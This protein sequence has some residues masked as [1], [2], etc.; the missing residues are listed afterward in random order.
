M[1]I[2]LIEFAVSSFV[3]EQLSSEKAKAL[4]L[5]EEESTQVLGHGA[6]RDDTGTPGADTAMSV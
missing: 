6:R 1:S 2:S 5:G 3:S 4:K